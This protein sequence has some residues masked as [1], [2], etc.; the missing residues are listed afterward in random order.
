[1]IKGY[2]WLW[3]HPYQ[4]RVKLVFCTMQ[5]EGNIVEITLLWQLFYKKVTTVLGS[6]NK[7]LL[8]HIAKAV[9]G[10]GDFSES[11]KKGKFVTKII[12]QIMLNEVI[13]SYEK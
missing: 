6:I 5:T 3:Y 9:E 4:G 11:V 1:M 7:K 13:K 8:S 12:F 2:G 10:V